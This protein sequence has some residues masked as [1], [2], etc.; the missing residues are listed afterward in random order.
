MDLLKILHPDAVRNAQSVGSK[1][2]LFQDLAVIASQNYGIDP[3]DAVEALLERENLGPTGVGRGVA[4]PH[5]RL[6]NLDRIVEHKDANDAELR[7]N[8]MNAGIYVFDSK[9]LFE[10]L[11][12]VGNN[13]AQGEYYLP[14]VLSLI[15]ERGGKVA[16]EKTNYITEIQG[17]NT[18][19]QLRD[20]DAEFQKI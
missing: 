9:T 8:E 12:Q 7:V 19:Q 20:L 14:D 3:E 1:K 15:L 10:L 18:I 17:V 2:R 13:N 4:L 16:I 5:A 6:E 11:P